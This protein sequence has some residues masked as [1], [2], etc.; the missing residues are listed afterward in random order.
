MDLSK[1]FDCLPHDLL[2]LKLKLYGLSEHAV[3][4][5]K[6]YLS[7]RKQCV[8]NGNFINGFKDI[9]K[10]VP[11]GSTIGPV[12]F[13]IF[14]N[15]IFYFIKDSDIYNY[16]DDNA[17]SYSHHDPKSLKQVLTQ[18]SFILIDWFSDNQ[19]QANPDK[20]QSLAVGSKSR[21]ENMV[22]NLGNDCLIN[23]DAEV[24][25]L[26]V[27]IDFKLK[28]DIHVSNICK[29]A[30]AQLGI[31]KR[32]GKNLCRLGKLNI[33]QPFVLSNFNFCP[34]TWH[35]CGETNT[36]KLEKIQEGALRFIYNDFNSN[37]EPLL[38]RSKMPTLKL[39][40]LRT[41]ALE[42]FKV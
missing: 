16:A 13:S 29:K 41:M 35:F 19:M 38:F 5:I 8:K 33:Y 32:I 26:G 31:L 42:V 18:D 4:L 1:A 11:Q 21:N 23:C 27:T 22:F 9:Y 40:R 20:F 30:S 7:S 12:L 39:Q 14:I 15:G 28:F 24:K 34:L 17:I 3:D 2:L 6:N 36:K 25:I 10:G 37:Y